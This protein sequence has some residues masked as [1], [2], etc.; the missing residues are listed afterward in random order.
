MPEGRPEPLGVTATAEGVNVAVVA[1]DAWAVWFCLFDASGTVELDRVALAART[2]DVW[3]GCIPG[4]AAGARY[5]LR[6]EGPRDAVHRF[7]PRKLL[8]DPWAQAIDRPFRLHGALWDNHEDS[9]AQMPKGIVCDA[10]PPAA[11]PPPLPGPR[12]IYEMHVRGFTMLHPE[13]PEPLR[14]TFAGLA[15]PAAIAHLRTL[16]VTHVEL[17]PCA[18]GID[19]RHL[20]ALGLTNYW[21]YNPVALLAPCP[22][23]APGGMAEV[24]AAVAALRAAGIGVI[25]D[26]VFNHTGESDEFGPTL[27]LRGLANRVFH[28]VLPDGRYA[29]DAGCGNTLAL[30]RPW[31][32]RLVMD[33]LRHWVVQAGVD[34]FRLDLAT[35]LGRRDDG[36][37]PNAPLLSAMRQDPLLRERIIIAEPWD[38]GPGGYQLGRFPP[39]WGEWNDRFRDDVR[40]FWRGDAG[41]LGAL[42]TRLAGSA[43]AF[44]GRRLSDSVNYVTAHDGFTAADLVSHA[45]RHNLA[46]GE[47]GRDGAGENLSWNNGAEG[48]SDDPGIRARRAADVRALLATLLLARGTPMLAMGD[49]AGRGQQGNNNAY[50]Q[51]NALSWFD[52]AGMDT[53]LRDF[54]ARLVR[55]RLAHPAL[56]GD[57]ALSEADVAW[58]TLDAAPLRD[59]H[60]SRSLAML[61]RRVEDRVLVV[62]HG[63]V[64]TATLALPP[65]REGHGWHLLADTAAP[66]R[67]GPVDNHEA[68]AP[69]SVLLLAECARPRA[70]LGAQLGAQPGVEPALLRQVALAA[71]IAPAW[72]DLA[73]RETQV[74]EA[75]LQ[76]L[77]QAM[78]LPAASQ[79]QAR[80]SLAL[81][82]APRPLPARLTVPAGQGITLHLGP[83]LAARGRLALLLRR[84][85]GSEQGFVIRADEGA[86]QGRHRRVALPPQPAGNHLL[87]V[88][89]ESCA[90]AVVPAACFAAP[91]ARRFG[92]AAQ[93]YGLRRATDQGIGDY[94]AI[95]E[96][97][98][99]AAGQGAL[100]LGLSPPHALSPL[101]RE[102]ASPYQPSDRRFLEPVLIDVAALPFDVAA[103]LTQQ[104]PTFAAL[105]RRD[106][107]DYTAVW[108]AK[109]AVL[110]AAWAGFG[111]HHPLWAEF[112]AFRAQQGAALRGFTAFT[113]LAEHLGHTDARQWPAAWRW[114]TAPGVAGFA[115]QHAAALG[116]HAFLQWLADRQLGQAARAGA[117]LYRDLAVGAAP[118]GAEAWAEAGSHLAAFS[119]GAP[120]DQFAPQ[121]Q[122]WGLPPPNP[123]AM[124]GGFPHL[125]QANMR[126]AAAL[127]IDHVMALTRLFV[128]PEGAPGSAGAYL[129]YPRRHLLGQLALASQQARCLVVGEDLGTVP[130]GFREELAAA[131]VLS[132]RVLWFER[133][134]EGF[135]P[136][137]EWPARAA[138]CVATHDLPTLAG[139]WLG[140]DLDEREALGLL[141][142]AAAARQ[143][144]AREREALLAALAEAGLAVAAPVLGTPPGPAFIAAVHALAASTPSALLLVQAEDLAGETSAV[145]LPGTDRERP[146]WRRRLP[147]PVAQLLHG[148]LARATLAALQGRCAQASVAAG[149]AG[150]ETARQ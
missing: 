41:M 67:Q 50:A 42:A 133:R 96:L 59:W 100:L 25:L 139:W 117:G 130:P 53:G 19:E 81:L 4:V 38:I 35:T 92:L 147:V 97:A 55:A 109:R 6:A 52:W 3:H 63:G 146:N 75:T 2:G 36:F 110:A 44:A 108:Q 11:A 86:W 66:L 73:G 137:A 18:A 65:P 88:E 10:L 131:E 64:E 119:I 45:H 124:L 113:A 49:E 13:V 26:V 30:D 127:R 126:H 22:K 80:E 136:P 91:A 14:G 104:E 125:L 118:D 107:V 95:G 40:R 1:P 90:L 138:A 74:P 21:N 150:V 43:D 142:E 39:G 105:R 144:R 60:D 132:Y 34:G 62:V 27:S 24:R 57:A 33:A 103:E 37:D 143:A 61:L 16:G 56:L 78:A 93:A 116:F 76:A 98:R 102:R 111:P 7:N 5:G 54:T 85:D 120:P 68:L 79:A 8:L 29:N 87:L 32:L 48:A 149:A 89:D 15:H 122:V 71:G 148:E 28:R 12:V 51:D 123:R 69:R 121:G 140:A 112:A 23:L 82:A 9:A 134:G 84:Q 129:A 128:V 114:G 17:L 135:I 70:Q 20:P 106:S 94:T 77:L 72:H 58:L 145:N 141:P 101:D 99:A 47:E 46:N 31:P 83:P 115:Q